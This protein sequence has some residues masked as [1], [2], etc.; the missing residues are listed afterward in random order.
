MKTISFLKQVIVSVCALG[1]ISCDDTP[2]HDYQGYG[3][4]VLVVCEGDFNSNNGAVTFISDSSVT[5]DVFSATNSRP[6]G[7]VVQ[8][9]EKGNENGYIVVNNSQKIEVVDLE[10]FE[11]VG[12][13]QG[14]SYPR[15][16]M[17]HDNGY[18]Y[19]TNG[20]GHASNMVYVVN[21]NNL[22]IEDSIAVGAGPDKIVS[23]D[24]KIFVTNRGGWINDSTV[25]V[26]SAQ[27]HVVDTT[28]AVGDVPVSIVPDNTG[29]LI[30]VCLGLTTYDADWNPTIVS[31]SKIVR[32][33]PETFE[34]EEVHSF[35][36]QL[37]TTGSNIAD[38]Y[39][40]DIYYIDNGVYKLEQNAQ[41]PEKII[42]GTFYGITVNPENGNI[43]VSNTE[44]E[45][46]HSVVIYSSDG[47]KIDEY[48]TEKWP[49]GVVF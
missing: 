39:E 9:L 5:Q 48:N 49:N 3:A 2:E 4:G 45:T 19:V 10:T 12:I 25:S 32:L 30:V 29:D 14:L 33:D 18:V 46:Q 43:W 26:I 13:I 20:N 15:Y 23:V 35:D 27:T 7:D 44:K 21:Q 8:S 22:Q 16:A 37:A 6:L 11:S 24:S 42:D 1:I 47:V 38:V 34:I 31:N 41:T 28:I 17:V 40:N 36:H